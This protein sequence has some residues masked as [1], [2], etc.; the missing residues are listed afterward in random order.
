M[1]WTRICARQRYFSPGDRPNHVPTACLTD[2]NGKTAAD[3]LRKAV[4]KS[5]TPFR[6]LWTPASRR[7]PPAK[8]EPRLS[9]LPN[10]KICLEIKLTR[11]YDPDRENRSL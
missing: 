8:P 10:G 11:R 1:I 4:E 2:F 7:T 9:V 3:P 6:S 5:K